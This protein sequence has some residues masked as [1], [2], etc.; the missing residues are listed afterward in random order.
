M[1]QALTA[2]A[3]ARTWAGERQVRENNIGIELDTS[4]TDGVNR[5]WPACGDLPQR[6]PSRLN[7]GPGQSDRPMT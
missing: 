2:Q 5:L 7:P 6:R 3:T 4:L 1:R